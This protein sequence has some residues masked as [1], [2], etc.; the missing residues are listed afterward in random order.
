MKIVFAFFL[1][2]SFRRARM[3]AWLAMEPELPALPRPLE[4]Q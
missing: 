1:G 4:V 2:I 3:V